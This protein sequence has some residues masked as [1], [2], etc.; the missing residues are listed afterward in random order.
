MIRIF[1]IGLLAIIVPTLSFAASTV[2]WSD[3]E[4]KVIVTN[5]FDDAVLCAGPVHI[6]YALDNSTTIVLGVEVISK[7]I[8]SN[9]SKEYVYKS[10]KNVKDVQAMVVCR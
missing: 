5:T 8:G 10:Y 4:V 3:N 7:I 6:K 2:T 1:F 9:S